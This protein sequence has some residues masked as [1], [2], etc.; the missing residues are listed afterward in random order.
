MKTRKPDQSEIA[1]SVEP[2][3]VNQVVG[4]SIPPLGAMKYLPIP[5]LT[6]TCIARLWNRIQCQSDTECWLWTGAKSKQGYGRFKLKGQL[7]SVTRLVYFLS[8]G[9]DPAPKHVCH[10][11]DVPG[12]CNPKHLW[13]GTAGENNNDSVQKG[14]YERKSTAR[15]GIRHPQ[16]KYNEQVK[17]QLQKLAMTMTVKRA[18]EILGVN[19]WSAYQIVRCG[20][21]YKCGLEQLVSSSGS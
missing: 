14:R 8:Y 13:L 16:Q 6:S 18:A 9:K 3:T 12:C 7:F 21:T 11:C 4:G 5:V 17:Q 20:H 10:T 1:Q 2:L 19:V 15:R